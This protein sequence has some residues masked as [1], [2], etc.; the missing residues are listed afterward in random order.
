MQAPLVVAPIPPEVRRVLIVGAGGFGREVSQWVRD[1]WG[2]RAALIAGF[3]SADAD[4]LEGHAGQLP[5]VGDPATYDPREGDGFL[6]A[7]GIPDTRRR[8][9]EALLARGATFLTLVHPTAI[10]SGFAVVGSGTVICPGAIVSDAVR[11]GRFVLVNY[12]ASLA[13][14]AQ[15]GD[16]AVL[17]PYATLAGGSSVGEDVFLGPHATVGPSVVIGRHSKVAAN[18]CALHD[19][20]AKS[21]VYGVPGRV[22]RLLA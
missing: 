4:A 17:S 18:S 10:V 8:V 6:L 2:D 14:D 20:P 13:H 1:A 12:H 19:A 3:L 21:L 5:I 22:T 16:F 11:V 9:A 15:A 7:I